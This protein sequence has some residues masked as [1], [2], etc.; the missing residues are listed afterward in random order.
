MIKVADNKKFWNRISGLYNIFVG[1]DKKAYAKLTNMISSK[2]DKDM[3]VLEIATG[4]GVIALNIA[5]HCKRIIATDF[6]EDMIKQAQ[7]QSV[8]SNLKFMVEDATKLSYKENSFDVVIISNALHIMPDPVKVL[9]NIKY[10][11]KDDGIL[12]CPNFTISQNLIERFYNFSMRIMG[13]KKFS[14]WSYKEYIDF[15]SDNGFS[16]EETN[17]IKAR[18]PMAFVVA[19]IK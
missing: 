15:I 13:F 7:K 9:N 3:T 10:V 16:I 2:L 1:A 19:K 4:T 18:Y 5:S 12:I 11:L 17:I 14:N 8:Y 6:S